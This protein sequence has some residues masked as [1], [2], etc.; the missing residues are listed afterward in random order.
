MIPTLRILNTATNNKQDIKPNSPNKT[1]L[2]DLCS[3][4]EL[5]TINK[6]PIPILLAATTSAKFLTNN[7]VSAEADGAMVST[8]KINIGISI[9]PNTI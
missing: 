1:F 8:E 4:T 9:R 2:A 6:N 7:I 3:L 5:A